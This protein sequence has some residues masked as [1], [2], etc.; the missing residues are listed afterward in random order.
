[1]P[2][3]SGEDVPS[4][5]TLLRR[6]RMAAGLTQEVLAERAGLSVRGLS[7]LERGISQSPR[8][9]TIGLLAR[10]MALSGPDRA[11]LAIAATSHPSARSVPVRTADDALSIRLTPLTRLLGRERDLEALAGLLAQPHVR[12][13]TLTGAGGSGKTR[14]ALQLASELGERRRVVAIGLASLRDHSLVASAIAHAL[15]ADTPA[16]RQP[17]ERIALEIGDAET[18]LVL[19]NFEHVLDAALLIPDVLERCPHLIVLVTSRAGLQ[20]RG[21]QEYPVPPLAL[22]GSSDCEA[23]TVA[24]SAA[25]ALLVER[26]RAVR[27]DFQLTPENAAPVVGICRRL[28]GLPL[29]VELAAA[30]LKLLSP[31]ALLSRLDHRL[32]ILNDG[33]RD[34]PTRQRTLR[35]TLAWSHELL[36]E[37]EQALFRRLAVFVGGCT[38]RAVSALCEGEDDG[39]L[40]IRLGSLVNHSLLTR[41]EGSDGEARLI[42][43]ETLREYALERLA[44]SGEEGAVRERHARYTFGLVGAGDAPLHGEERRRWQARLEAELGNVRDALAWS[45][46]RAETARMGLQAA[47]ALQQFW[48]QRGTLEEGQEWLDRALV[49]TEDM[50]CD[51]RSRAL[52]AAAHLA[53]H[54]GDLSRA[55]WLLERALAIARERDDRPAIAEAQSFL[56]WLARQQ[57]APDR[58]RALLQESLAIWRAL[59]PSPR[60][61][62]GIYITLCDLASMVQRDHEYAEAHACYDEA[63]VYCRSF[64]DPTETIGLLAARAR[65][66]LARGAPAEARTL[67]T[68]GMGLVSAIVDRRDRGSAAELLGWTSYRNGQ[69]V[70]ATRLLE[71]SLILARQLRNVDRVAWSL[72]HLGDVARSAG[73][74]A[75]AR[76]RYDEA[77]PLFQARRHTQGAAAVIHNLGHLALA[78][79]DVQRAAALFEQSLRLFVEVGYTWSV[80]D[81]LAGLG[82]VAVRRGDLERAARLF[83]AAMAIH[84][85]I[86]AT[87]TFKDPSSEGAWDEHR[88]LAQ[89]AAPVVWERA[90]AEGLACTLSGAVAYA[91]GGSWAPAARS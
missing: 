57:G 20:V 18:L 54:R 5:G 74:H 38:L 82:C 85:S 23:E 17:L 60:V 91:L 80:G 47:T 63:A 69:T 37:P 6:Y 84:D 58:A 66:A 30:R 3:N 49:I 79:A 52:S 40:M 10:A 25:V 33:P 29:A 14:L 50:E 64:D 51:V 7:D 75:E 72:N 67:V 46:S 86:D 78:E 16:E 2:G 53:G 65:L 26:A 22:P 42:M 1:M 4:F 76:A 21:E 48:E 35:A 55:R 15:G 59:S 87:G 27:P 71:E 9:D 56:G 39:D 34:L 88:R 61:H 32:G 45:L 68:E 81:A 12:L 89:E 70:E 19:D 73:E 43:L 41:A 31:Q 24:R 44:A 90:L 77:L 83:G 8:A 13:L 11:A 36:S 28:D 62:W